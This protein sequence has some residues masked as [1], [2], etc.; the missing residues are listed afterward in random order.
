MNALF[1]VPKTRYRV[2]NVIAYPNST[3]V[4]TCVPNYRHSQRRIDSARLL[5]GSI[6][7]QRFLTLIL[8]NRKATRFSSKL[9]HS[10]ALELLF[11]LLDFH[12]FY[13][14]DCKIVVIAFILK[15]Q[16]AKT[17]YRPGA[18]SVCKLLSL[19]WPGFG[20]QQIAQFALAYA[21]RTSLDIAKKP[22]EQ[23]YT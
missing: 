9:Y 22:V 4:S 3:I 20:L 7:I 11:N 6:T 17:H 16:D 18:G 13:T 21:I 5:Q 1:S 23:R 15:S 19:G 8:L 12:A 14:Y 2:A 10:N